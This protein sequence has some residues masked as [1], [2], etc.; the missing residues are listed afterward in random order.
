MFTTAFA[1]LRFLELNGHD[2]TRTLLNH[3]YDHA[4]FLTLFSGAHTPASRQTP[5]TIFLRVGGEKTKK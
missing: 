2:T 4:I 5:E 3:V 1:I